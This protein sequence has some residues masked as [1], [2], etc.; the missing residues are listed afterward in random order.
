MNFAMVVEFACLLERHRTR[1][2]IGT[3]LFVVPTIGLDLL[4]ALVI[5]RLDRR[6]LVLTNV[7]ATPTAEWIAHQLTEAFP[8]N[9][10]GWPLHHMW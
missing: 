7:T 10:A 3:D 8:R 9:E 4:Y 2:L 6:D 1:R 5:V